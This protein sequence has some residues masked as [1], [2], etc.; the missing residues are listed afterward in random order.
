MFY[1]PLKNFSSRF[2][3]IYFFC[4][5]CL[6]YTIDEFGR[7]KIK[8]KTTRKFLWQNE[9]LFHFFLHLFLF[10]VR[11]L[12]RIFIQIYAIIRHTSDTMYRRRR[13]KGGLTDGWMIH[14]WF[15]ICIRRCWHSLLPFMVFDERKI[16]AGKVL[17]CTDIRKTFYSFKVC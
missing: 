16:C 3:F 17:I 15:A 8:M 11:L 2:V 13:K 6:Y 5:L 10:Y 7:S 14:L 12:L 1:A 9:Q 4:A